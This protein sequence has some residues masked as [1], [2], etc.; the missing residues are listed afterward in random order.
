M[1]SIAPTTTR[2]ARALEGR[3]DG[4]PLDRGRDAERERSFR[5][6]KGCKDMPALVAALARHAEEVAGTTAASD[7]PG[8]SP[9]F[10]SVRDTLVHSV[11]SW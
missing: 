2:N 1:I 5:R 9:N 6:V 3:R 7:A 10:N 11:S 8:P 4:A